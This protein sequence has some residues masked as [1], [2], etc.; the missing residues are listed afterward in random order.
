MTQNTAMQKKSMREAMN[1]AIWLMATVWPLLLA[2]HAYLEV[3]F[4]QGIPAAVSPELP[5][6]IG[7][8][9]NFKV[10]GFGVFAGMLL[11]QLLLFLMEKRKP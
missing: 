9:Q 1:P 8:W 6:L 5:K 3:K 10:V 2:I 4:L 7:Q 11:L